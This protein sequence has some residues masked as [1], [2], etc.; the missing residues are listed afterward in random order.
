MVLFFQFFGLQEFALQG[1]PYQQISNVRGLRS[2]ERLVL[3]TAIS[4]VVG[5]VASGCTSPMDSTGFACYFAR[6]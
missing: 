6:I 4:A 5:L 2:T 1:P 3:V